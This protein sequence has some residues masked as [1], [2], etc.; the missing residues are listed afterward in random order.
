MSESPEEPRGP[1]RRP[2]GAPEIPD[3][4]RHQPSRRRDR[5]E[6]DRPPLLSVPGGKSPETKAI[7]LAID[8]VITLAVGSLGGWL[9]DKWLGTGTRW[10][11][12]GS[13]VGIVVAIYFFAKGAR[14]LNRDLDRQKP[15]EP[16]RGP[17]TDAD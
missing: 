11:L 3:V 5:G 7:V 10:T 14:R 6:G 8:F 12:V 1:S 4:L 17:E 15:G 9:V 13:I 16:G 2:S